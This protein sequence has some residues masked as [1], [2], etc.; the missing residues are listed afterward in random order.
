MRDIKDI[1]LNSTYSKETADK[2]WLFIGLAIPAISSAVFY[3][4]SML[5]D[6][7]GV[8][9]LMWTI[10][11]CVVWYIY[12][13]RL[14]VRE[15]KFS[16]AFWWM[17]GGAIALSIF[18]FITIIMWPD[19]PVFLK[20]IS[21]LHSFYMLCFSGLTV[22]TISHISVL[23]ESVNYYRWMPIAPI[24]ATLLNIALFSLGFDRNLNKNE[25]IKGI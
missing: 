25:N 9:S 18:S 21:S 16:R 10:L 12:S 24:I 11:T 2:M 5:F 14:Y 4:L 23:F 6:A 15:I 3:G 19:T 1:L 17:N 13:Y 20:K 7:T 8:F 22:P